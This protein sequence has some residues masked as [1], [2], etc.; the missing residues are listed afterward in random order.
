MCGCALA[1]AALVGGTVAYQGTGGGTQGSDLPPAGIG[2]ADPHI[3]QANIG[4][5]ICVSGYSATVRPSSSFTGKIKRE[6]L[7]GGNAADFEL[8]H[9][10]AIEDGGAPA[11]RSNLWLQ[12]WDGPHGAHVK[13]ALENLIHKKLCD[14]SM[15][16]AE[17]GACFV[18]NWIECWNRLKP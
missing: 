6:L 5:T 10:W 11:D 18:I 9:A 12:K 13:D 4:T 1:I 7:N 8:D 16:L 14:G 17:A 15:S 3:T 2:V